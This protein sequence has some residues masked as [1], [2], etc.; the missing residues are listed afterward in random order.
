[1]I[2]KIDDLAVNA[3]RILSVDQVQQANSGHPGMP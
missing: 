2:N 3:L 1:M